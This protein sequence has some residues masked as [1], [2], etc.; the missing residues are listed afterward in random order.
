MVIKT[1]RSL[2]RW[3][4]RCV[5]SWSAN[6]LRSFFWRTNDLDHYEFLITEVLLARSNA[7][8]VN[9]VAPKLIEEYSNIES[10]SK[11]QLKSIE[12]I[13]YPL[14]LYKK[15]AQSLINLAN[16]L[17]E[18]YDSKIPMKMKVLLSLP[19]V[20]RYVTN[21]FLCFSA[22]RRIAVVDSNV[23]RIFERC[24]SLERV[25]DKLSENEEYW[26]L[27]N[28]LLPHKK[29]KEYNWALLDIGSIVCKRGKPRCNECELHTHCSFNNKV[30][31]SS[32]SNGGS[33]R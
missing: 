20:G 9:K 22:G 15:R 19:Y 28:K 23:A 31:R 7:E 2:M 13:I 14:G 26:R 27:A 5:L 12:R 17:D 11:A 10:L 18:K 3:F 16:V 6:N 30:H 1:D 32:H 33:F 21:A 4:R 8:L 24:F 29:V 25:K